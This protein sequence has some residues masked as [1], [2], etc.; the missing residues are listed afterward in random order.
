MTTKLKSGMTVH[1]GRMLLEETK[2]FS[3]E[4]KAV[5]EYV[6][7]SWQYT[8]HDPTVE[9]FVNH[10][11]KSIRIVDNSNGM[12]IDDI[13][14]RFLVLHQENVERARKDRR[15]EFGTGKIAALGIGEILRVRTVRNKKINEFE[16]IDQ[17]AMLQFQKRRLKYIGLNLIKIP[18]KKMEQ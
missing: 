11:D 8:D 2:R 3:N 13:N 6:K 14:K 18:Q 16:L 5:G 7:N 10:D 12:D 1:A 9:I 15:G 4:G 17:T